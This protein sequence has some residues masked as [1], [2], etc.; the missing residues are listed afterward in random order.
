MTRVVQARTRQ[1]ILVFDSA[2]DANNPPER[3]ALFDED[4]HPVNVN[5]GEVGPPGADGESAYEIAVT[6]GFVGTEQEWLASLEGAPGPPGA[7]GPEGPPGPAGPAGA[8][9][10]VPGPQGPEGPPGPAGP[11]GADST[12][13]GPEGPPGPAGP[14]GP[15]GPAGADSTVPGPQG[16]EGPPGP[17]G[18][19]STVPG[20]QGPEGPP[21]PPGDLTVR[22]A[23]THTTASLANN[24]SEQ[25]SVVLYEGYRVLRV[26]TDI[27]ARVR[28]YA[29]AAQQAADAARAIGTDPAGNHGVVL[30]VVT[31][32]GNLAYALSPIP[33]GFSMEAVPSANIPITVTNLSGAT[34]TVAVTLTYQRTE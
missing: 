4:G 18:A 16:P 30:E 13:P 28:L 25:S 10:T 32:V 11:A 14:E 3:W 8:D 20:P 24:A 23:K 6:N 19:D 27:P 1:G 15:P 34:G 17:A 2:F 12:V 5:G 29:T 26:E 31:E 22:E 33:H 9:S 21:G 7:D